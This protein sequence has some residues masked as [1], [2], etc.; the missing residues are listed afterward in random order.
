MVPPVR[1]SRRQVATVSQAP[2]REFF[3]QPE[4]EAT[5]TS[6]EEPNLTSSQPLGTR[7]SRRNR[8]TNRRPRE[9]GYEPTL[10]RRKR[11]GRQ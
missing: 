9:E 5:P 3:S 2:G 7:S 1:R 4:P 10:K 11:G 6:E 8:G